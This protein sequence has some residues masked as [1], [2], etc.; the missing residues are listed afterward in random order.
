MKKSIFILILLI[1]FC[2]CKKESSETVQAPLIETN[3]VLSYIQ[4]T[5]T[6]TITN[7]PADASGKISIVFTDSLNVIS[8]SGICNVG[9]G[10]YSY[11][12][13]TGEIEI[14]NLSCTKIACKYVEWE[15]YTTQ[16][17][18][19][20]VSYKINGNNLFIYSGSTYNLSFTKE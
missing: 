1:S 20:A 13:T 5:K 2:G 6:S 3:W 19:N 7:F 15:G 12:S 4:D 11:S 18:S 14:N 17:L 8:F 16:N 10:S 9:G